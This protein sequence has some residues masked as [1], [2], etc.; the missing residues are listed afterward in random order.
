LK[1][2]IDQKVAEKQQHWQKELVSLKADLDR[3]AKIEERRHDAKAVLDHYREP[4]LDAAYDLG[5]RIDNILHR[6]FSAYFQGGHPIGRIAVLSTL[7]RFSRYFGTLEILYSEVSFLRF[8]ES[9]ATRNVAGLLADIARTFARD[10][11]DRADGSSRFMIWREEQ[12]AIGELSIYRNGD[13]APRCVGF[14]TFSQQFDERYGTWFTTF[15]SDL[16]SGD[17]A[18]SERL[19]RLQSLLADLVRQ[20]DDQG[21]Y[22]GSAG[23]QGRPPE[24][25]TRPQPTIAGRGV[26]NP[27]SD[28]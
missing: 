25:M 26:A 14:A 13:A 18:N 17:A 22:V 15:V 3:M 4:L 11:Y 28:S 23:A 24:W 16:K 2:D 21:R 20:L 6:G 12:R 19:A 9:E 27:R 7:Y 8:E 1:G 10:S 5:E